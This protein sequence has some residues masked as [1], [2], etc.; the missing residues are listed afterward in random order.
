MSSCSVSLA[1]LRRTLNLSTRASKFLARHLQVSRGSTGWSF[2]NGPSSPGTALLSTVGTTAQDAQRRAQPATAAERHFG[3]RDAS[4]ELRKLG[5]RTAADLD[6][7]GAEVTRQECQLRNDQ[8]GTSFIYDLRR[9]DEGST[10]APTAPTAP[11]AEERT[12]FDAVAALW[13]G[14]GISQDPP[15]AEHPGELNGSSPWTVRAV[16]TTSGE[17]FISTECLV[18]PG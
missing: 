4:G 16:A 15:S 3:D 17:V 1:A 11:T 8:P 10:A 12:R 6:P 14:A 18:E 7:A 2:S 5:A 13:S 9:P